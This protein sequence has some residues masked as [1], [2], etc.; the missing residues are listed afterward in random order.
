MNIGDRSSVQR[1]VQKIVAYVV[2]WTP[3]GVRPR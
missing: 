3:P 2:R 1:G